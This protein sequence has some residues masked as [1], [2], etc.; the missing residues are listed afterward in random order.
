MS[1]KRKIALVACEEKKFD[2]GKTLYKCMT[3]DGKK[4][5]CWEAKIKEFIG[6]G[7]HEFNVFSK[8]RNGTIDWY[9]D[10][11]E[12][13]SKGGGG[14]WGG[15]QYT[16]SFAQ[17]AEA[18]KHRSTMMAMSYAKDA[19]LGVVA[20][21]TRDIHAFLK[22]FDIAFDH[23]MSKAKL[24]SLQDPKPEAQPAAGGNGNGSSSQGSDKAVK[25]LGEMRTIKALDALGKWW[26][27]HWNTINALNDDEKNLLIAEKDK[28][29]ASFS[30]KKGPDF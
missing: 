2:S 22:D 30:S 10:L 12:P 20:P 14:K 19:A 5:D 17:T 21:N 7:E 27:A 23:F 29:K 24:D 3:A 15:K 4:Y 8:D 25:L 1:E 6:K 16:P 26:T 11:R 28:M 13:G 18:E 9:I